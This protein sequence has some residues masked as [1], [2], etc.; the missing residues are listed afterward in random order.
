MA[1]YYF[2]SKGYSEQKRTHPPSLMCP[3]L[4]YRTIAEV[5]TGS[6]NSTVVYYL[7]YSYKIIEMTS[8]CYGGIISIRT[9]VQSMRF[10]YVPAETVKRPILDNGYIRW[11]FEM[12]ASYWKLQGG[13]SAG[14]AAFNILL[15][16]TSKADHDKGDE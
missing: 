9:A 7:D 11:T 8:S 5:A 1:I 13:D 2:W 10:I 12:N 16:A 15:D 6:D 3:P 4:S 14:S